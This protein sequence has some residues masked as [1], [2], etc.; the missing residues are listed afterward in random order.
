MSAHWSAPASLLAQM[1]HFAV[2]FAVPSF[3]AAQGHPAWWGGAAILIVAGFKEL[4]FDR[5][6]EG[7]KVQG[8]LLDL[9]FY[10][11]GAGFACLLI[12][13]K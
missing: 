10:A 13:A 8:N 3:V 6:V 2:G 11:L 9:F 5:I 1:L 4:T 7:Q 12:L